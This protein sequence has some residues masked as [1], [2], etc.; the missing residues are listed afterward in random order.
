[1]DTKP[2]DIRSLTA[3]MD[4][5]SSP[6]QLPLGVPRFVRNLR[7][8]EKNK[9][10]RVDG[11]DK[12][13]TR[14]DY[15]NQDLHD[16]LRSLTGF[17]QD[18][19]ITFL[20]EAISTRKT[21]KLLAGTGKAL[22]ALNNGTGNWKVLTSSMGSPETRWR[23][24]MLRDTVFF[25][26]NSDPM[27]YWQFD[28]G[29]TEGTASVA[30]VDDLRDTVKISKVG[31]IVTFKEHVFLMNVVENGT[32]R[33]NRV[34]WCDYQHPLSWVPGEDS[35]AGNFDLDD[36]ETILS[37]AP[38]GNR[39]L[40]YTTRGIWECVVSGTDS[41]FA[42]NK[43]YEPD[44]T[45]ASCLYYPNT[46]V[47]IGN[48]HWYMGTDGIYQYNLFQDA[49][50][51]IQWVHAAS[52]VMFS[53]IDHVNCQLPVAA[54]DHTH[55][56]LFFF[57]AKTGESLPSAGL[58]LNLENPHAYDL[59]YGCSAV[60]GYTLNEPVQIARDFLLDRCICSEADF[61]TYFGGLDQEGGF[62]TAQETAN[63]PTPPQSIYSK[64]S[65]T[66][67]AGI[68]TEDYTRDTA[69]ADSLCA[70]LAGITLSQL[71]ESEQREDECNSG[72][73]FVAASSTDFCLKEFSVNHYREE[74]TNKAGCGT[75]QKRGY[76]SLLRSGAI[77]AGDFE[78]DKQIDDF[79][80]EA[81]ALPSVVPGQFTLRVGMQKQAVDPNDDTCGIVWDDQDP[82]EIQCLS[83][84]TAAQHKTAN[85]IPDMPYSWP[86]YYIGRYLYFEL[87]IENSKASPIDT[88]AACCLSRITIAVK[89]RLVN[90]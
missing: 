16:Q 86:L 85:T 6:D 47:S 13:L 65:L 72:F 44:K 61:G 8:G 3:P 19:P 39:L 70:Q 40:I 42:F 10:C 80:L 64:T 81:D 35:T 25:T 58:V 63:C 36:G 73:R 51:R 45:G 2:L 33:S 43:R 79:A 82:Q 12:L 84:A 90:Y 1:M 18:Y 30:E 68:A 20:F 15:N 48:G 22:Y 41:V 5:R 38:M 54:Y 14:A 78:N 89:Q 56:E 50:Q 83:G 7:V 53:N 71:C 34:Y 27:V 46:L 88:G 4:T 69:D 9:L 67:E 87:G 29:I 31:T 17:S 26:N 28:Q 60:A 24:T 66:L 23:A 77:S 52:G 21:R 11:F 75:Y 76:K 49:P 57:Y 59:D 62:C 74:C 32:V 55:K 37:A